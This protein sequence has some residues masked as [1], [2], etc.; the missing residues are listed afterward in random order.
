M[1]KIMFNED[2]TH[3]LYNRIARNIAITREEIENFIYQYKDTQI[4]DFSMNVNAQIASFPSK[5]ME[6]FLDKYYAVEEEGVPVDYKDNDICR[7]MHIIYEKLGID[8]YSC[9]INALRK[10]NIRPWIS[11]RMN[12]CHH[13]WQIHHVMIS[14]KSRTRKDWYRVKHRQPPVGMQRANEDFYYWDKCFDY[15]NP[16]VRNYML[17]FISEVLERYD[18]DGL[19]LDFTRELPSFAI[20]YEA[21]GR[22]IMTN[23]VSS[24]KEMVDRIGKKRNKKIYLQTMIGADPETVY[25]WGYDFFA[26]AR[27][28]LIDSLV[29][30]PRWE[31]VYTE[32]PVRFWKELLSP[33]KVEF[34]AGNQILTCDYPGGK[35]SSSTLETALGTACAYRSQGAD[36]TYL[37]NFMDYSG[38][39]FGEKWFRDEKRNETVIRPHNLS[40]MLKSSGEIS[41]MLNKRRRHLVSFND[42]PNLW[43]KPVSRLPFE[44]NDTNVYQIIRVMVGEVPVDSNIKLMFGIRSSDLLEDSNFTVFVN[45]VKC[46]L[47]DVFCVDEESGL[48]AYTFDVPDGIVIKDYI[49]A[50]IKNNNAPFTVE[51]IEADIE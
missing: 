18:I 3:F 44:C 27:K 19:E 50:E 15:A 29:A 16:E 8:L 20:G 4:T 46:R 11:V 5:V 33:Y 48:T 9:W 7:S 32:L 47:S 12:D 1:K 41:T 36:F 42:F 14:E 13:N 22:E 40:Q 37:Y 34:A 21:A 38:Y 10:I 17:D 39:E 45:T 2:W 28:G 43:N 24:V 25:D 49:V 51:H 31:T 6:N 26:W 35:E 30:I 23:F